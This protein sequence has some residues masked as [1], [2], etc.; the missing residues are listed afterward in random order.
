MDGIEE[1]RKKYMKNPPE[2]FTAKEIEKISA[3]DILDMDYFLMNNLYTLSKGS[4]LMPFFLVFFENFPNNKKRDQ[5][6]NANLSK[7]FL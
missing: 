7:T 6:Y 3:E 2:G 1:L 4:F 5:H